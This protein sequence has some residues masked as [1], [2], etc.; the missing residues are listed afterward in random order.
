MRGRMIQV[1][2]NHREDAVM[3]AVA[4]D[5]AQRAMEIVRTRVATDGQYLVDLGRVSADLI[6][7]LKLAPGQ[8]KKV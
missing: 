5:D 2:G 7:T 3:Y 8:W 6:E 4:E 1:S